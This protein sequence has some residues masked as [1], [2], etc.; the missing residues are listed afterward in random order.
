MNISIF[1]AQL[2]AITFLAVGLGL[3]FEVK[4]YHKV[5]DDIMKE[6][7]VLY[8]GGIAALVVGFLIV[9]HHNIWQDWPMLIT[10]LGW[11][12]LIKGFLLLAFPK[13]MIRWTKN[14]IA[15]KHFLQIWGSIAI[16]LSIIFG[17]L[18]F[19]VACLV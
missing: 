12:S 3:L 13:Y 16:M 11:I 14:W 9:T 5:F 1:I 15:N 6:P 4:Y 18:G 8:I 7:G 19:C 10:I 2:F 17:Y